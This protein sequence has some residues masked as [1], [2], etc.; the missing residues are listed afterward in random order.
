MSAQLPILL[1]ALAAVPL[2]GQ[3]K[4]NQGALV[5]QDFQKRVDG[6]IKVHRDASSHLPPLKSTRT[7]GEIARRETA[8]AGKI[9]E[10]RADAAQGDIFTPEIAA[11]FRLLIAAA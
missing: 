1:C 6:Y 8:L 2:P 4:V 9:R 11:Q 3:E 10:A 7:P 5:L